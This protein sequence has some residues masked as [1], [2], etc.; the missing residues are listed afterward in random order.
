MRYWRSQTSLAADVTTI[1]G[2]YVRSTRFVSIGSLTS[3]TITAPSNSTIVLDDFGGTV[4][5][6]VTQISG[7]KP[8]QRPA[9]T[10]LGSVVAATFD[11]SGNWTF[12]GTPVSYPVALVY[13]VKQ[14]LINFDSTASDIW[15]DTEVDSSTPGSFGITVDGGGQAITTGVKGFVSIPYDCTIIGWDLFADQSG[16]IVFDVWKRAYASFPP[17]VSQTITASA[18]PTLSSVQKNSDSTLTGWTTSV[19]AGDVIGFNVDSATTVTRANLI[20]RVQR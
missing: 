13:R 1:G 15:G 8:T 2:K 5:A 16:S 20:L 4:D 10:S 12:S 18:K 14:T 9:L 3:G 17:T 6:V 7:G 11:G 19:S